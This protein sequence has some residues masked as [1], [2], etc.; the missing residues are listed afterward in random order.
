MASWTV[1]GETDP[2]TY[3]QD[4]DAVDSLTVDGTEVW[5]EADQSEYLNLA[6]HVPQDAMD[7]W[8]AKPD[9]Q[10]AYATAQPS[11]EF[12]DRGANLS[13]A[14]ESASA[15]D[16]ILNL[17]SGG[18]YEMETEVSE[19]GTFG[20]IGDPD[21]RP[22][23][24]Y[25]GND[26]PRLFSGGNV[27]DTFV[28]EGLI[29]DITEDDPNFG[30]GETT[31]ISL[32]NVR[33]SNE[34]WVED[35]RLEGQRQRI[36]NDSSGVRDRMTWLIQMT[37]TDATA[38]MHRVEFPDGG[39]AGVEGAGGNAIGWSADPNHEGLNVAK[40]CHVEGFYDNGFYVANSNGQNILWD[41]YA[42]NCRAG[43]FRLGTYAAWSRRDIVIGGTSEHNPDGDAQ[44][45][46]IV[47]DHPHGEFIGVECILDNNS[48][49]AGLVV[50]S[51][52]V[53]SVLHKVTLDVRTGDQVPA[54]FGSTNT[55][56]LTLGIRDVYWYDGVGATQ[57]VTR[58]GYGSSTCEAGTWRDDASEFRVDSV[59]SY[60]LEVT[61]ADSSLTVG[62]DVYGEGYYTASDLGMGDPHVDFNGL[63][64]FYFEYENPP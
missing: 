52:S 12:E 14:I 1:D 53:E 21:N 3:T 22:R 64:D 46:C 47:Q 6:S 61:N 48:W 9:I 2:D 42:A 32:A 62:S 63:P 29:F 49:S 45:Q 16:Q 58:I 13:Q 8:H 19:L 20:V 30:S 50:R 17:G 31:D 10:S 15:N 44:G 4:G 34:V 43:N 40:G 37:Q 51:G 56:P 33:A 35:V 25:V 28:L 7:L 57:A 11:S 36:Q 55:D 24:Y 26:V 38:F 54:R 39:T 59:Q 18:E 27:A 41:C 5:T 23:I 60:E